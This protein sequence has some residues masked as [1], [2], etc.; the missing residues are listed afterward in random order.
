[1]AERNKALEDFLSGFR[2][3]MD[4]GSEDFREAYFEA[5]KA[6]GID[7]TDSQKFS[8]MIGTN[9]TITTLRDLTGTS[10]PED[11]EARR[12]LGM[13]IKQTTPGK[14]GQLLGRLGNDI[15]NDKTRSIWWL[16][17]APQAVATVG[18]EAAVSQAN[19]NLYKQDYVQRPGINTKVDRRM[20]VDPKTQKAAIDMGILDEKTK[21]MKAGYSK[22]Y[23]P[24]TKS[25]YYTKRRYAPGAVATL[26]A[27]AALAV[28][29]GMGLTNFMG[30]TDG[31]T[32]ALPSQEDPTKTSNILGEI[33][34]KYILGRTG[35]LLPYD[36]FRKVRPDV[37][38]GDYMRYKAFKY[39]KKG[40]LN[41]FDDGQ[42]TLPT[43]VLKAT[44]EGI[45]GPEVQFLGRSLPVAT[46]ILP[47]VA[48]IAGTASGVRTKT[49]I[50]QGLMRGFGAYGVA[51]IA[52]NII[53]NE[54][55]NR[56]AATHA[57]MPTTMAINPEASE[58]GF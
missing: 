27:P 23:D 45:H 17:N 34:A 12:A 20:R 41:P 10:N 22:Q 53:E 5:R 15:I 58:V 16:L 19:P 56:N 52:G 31:Y 28:N 50:R 7:P 14:A 48:A 3:S 2:G 57:Q 43:G 1:M 8:Q 33:A 46:T 36:E 55:R 4:E 49:P 6:K 26:T 37:S 35:Q 21:R 13:G 18:A 42:I 39:D 47:T 38:K 30:G 40:D 24:E 51:A 11:R 44:T 25:Q 32:A 9:P 54:R 29:A